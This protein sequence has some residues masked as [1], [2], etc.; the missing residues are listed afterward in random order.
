MI[1]RI[2]FLSS[3]FFFSLSTSAIAATE[4]EVNG[5]TCKKVSGFSKHTGELI[6]RKLGVSVSSIQ[7]YGIDPWSGD[8]YCGVKVDTPLGVKTVKYYTVMKNGK[9]LRDGNDYWIHITYL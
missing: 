8:D 3:I 2:V 9:V 5:E 4:L 7:F 6:S 1:H